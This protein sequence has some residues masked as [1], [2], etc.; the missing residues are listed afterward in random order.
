MCVC[1]WVTLLYNRKW[2]EHCKPTIIEKIKIIKRKEK[3]AVNGHLETAPPPRVWT[4]RGC[5]EISCPIRR[6]KQM[7]DQA[8]GAGIAAAAGVAAD[9]GVMPHPEEL[10]SGWEQTWAFAIG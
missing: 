1:D 8:G 6:I 5:S 3:K 2:T 10:S 4:P 9:G 7:R